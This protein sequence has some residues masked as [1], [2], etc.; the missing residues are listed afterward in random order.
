M[1]ADE[2]MDEYAGKQGW[3]EGSQLALALDYIENQKDNA[4]FE[5]F[6]KQAVGVED[7]AT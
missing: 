3:N 6:L 7:A 1:R 5:D 4:C 2:L